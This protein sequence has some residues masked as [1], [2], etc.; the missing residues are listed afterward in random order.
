MDWIIGDGV[1][2]DFG[3]VAG[4]EGVKE[5]IFGGGD[6][7]VGWEH[8]EDGGFVLFEEER[9]AVGVWF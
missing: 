1:G 8:E 4:F 2:V 5:S 3:Y 9:P 6:G 7:I